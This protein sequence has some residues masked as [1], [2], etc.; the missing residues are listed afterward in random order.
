MPRPR[1]PII[2]HLGPEEIAQRYRRCKDGLEKTHWQVLW[3]LTRAQDPLTPAQVA[4]HV[5]LTPSWVRTILKRWN[6]QGPQGLLDRRATTNGGQSKLTEEQQAQLREALQQRPADGGLW[7][8]PKVAA[9]V[10]QRWGV[11]VGQ[12]TGWKWLRRLGFTL[13][14]PRPGHPK[15][16]SAARRQEWKR[17]LGP[18]DRGPPRRASRAGR[19]TLGGG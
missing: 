11:I 4:D 3:L 15:A 10:R 5:G 17:D 16:A 12:V 19:G 18:P 14:V 1:L 2:L 8:G 9:Y 7:S 6:A 13:Q